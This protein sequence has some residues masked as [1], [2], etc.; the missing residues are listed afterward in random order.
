M[1]KRQ[2]SQ[3]VLKVIA[4]ILLI[5]GAVSLLW[6]V[7]RIE[8]AKPLLRDKSSLL[9]R[10]QAVSQEHHK[11]SSAHQWF[12]NQPDKRPV[13]LQQLLTAAKITTK[14]SDTH[15]TTEQLTS[16]WILQ[17][18]ELVFDSMH[19]DSAESIIA[20]AALNFP[21]WRLTRFTITATQNGKMCRVVL[22]FQTII[23]K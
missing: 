7:D 23:R 9:R 22:A 12:V 2:P 19:L 6:S 21:A 13:S 5:G 10:L 3:T 11:Y 15:V 18:Q 16:G 4:G 20:Q 8:K 17:E 14:P 1:S